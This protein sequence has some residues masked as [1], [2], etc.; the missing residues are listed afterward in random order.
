M[1]TAQQFRLL[2]RHYLL[3]LL[4]ASWNGGIGALA[5]ILGI[6]GASVSGI[7]TE[8]RVLNWEEMSAAFAG[9]FVVSGIFWLKAH[10]LPE[11]WAKIA[12]QQQDNTPPSP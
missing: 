10:P 8:I 4:S 6:T 5:G 12:Q 3:G 7:S 2:A 11:D 1:P 9:A